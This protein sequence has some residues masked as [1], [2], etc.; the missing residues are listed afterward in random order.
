[1]L[2]Y[3][4]IIT[5]MIRYLII[6]CW[7]FYEFVTFNNYLSA[8]VYEEVFPNGF[9]EG[10]KLR[11]DNIPNI[12]NKLY[13]LIVF[14]IIIYL[15][16]IVIDF[17]KEQNLK[18]SLKNIALP[19][20]GF[21]VIILPKYWVSGCFMLDELFHL[22]KFANCFVISIIIILGL[23]FFKRKKPNNSN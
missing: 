1:M 21:A 9:T 20:I 3:K 11:I 4:N 13:Y 17:W 7:S 14:L 23:K 16:I 6:I 22:R 18:E 19:I 10:E 5:V 15:C 2:K 8:L 12:T